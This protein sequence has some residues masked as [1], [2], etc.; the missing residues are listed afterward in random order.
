[1]FDRPRIIPTLLIKDD[2]LVKTI[3]FAS[4]N[5]LGDVINA[6]KIF[7]EKFVDELCILDISA[8]QRGT[9]NFD[10]LKQIASEAFMPMS[11]GGNIKSLE[12]AKKIFSIGFEKIV[13]NNILISNPTVV[14]EICRY[15]GS[16]S[17]IASI[18][19]R[20]TIFK[21]KRCF[22]KG[23]TICTKFLPKELVLKA[24]SLGVGEILLTSIDND[25]MMKGFDI[26][27]VKE[28]SDLSN[29]PVIA[30]GG[31]GSLDDIKRVLEIG[32]ADAVAVGSLFV[33]YG[34]KKAVLINYPS[35]QDFILSGI[36]EV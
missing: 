35:E 19:V 1:M 25:G 30:C 24:I 16:Q 12:E 17:V 36:Y 23:K 33:Y 27:L 8:E 21:G 29:V 5:Y 7:N 9:I 11:Y 20:K 3:K 6:V 13:V 4:P 32:K 22:S 10:L 26:E 2:N 28:I 15:A 31:A 14:S 18:D 34:P